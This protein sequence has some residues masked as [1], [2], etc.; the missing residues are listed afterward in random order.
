[1]E[2]QRIEGTRSL[3]GG[4]PCRSCRFECATSPTARR[5]DG[6]DVDLSHFHHR[7]ERALRSS[8][9]GVGYRLSQ[10]DR[11]NL[12]GQSPSVLAPAARALFAAVPYDRV[13]VT[14]RFGLVRGCDLKRERFVVLE[15]G[16]AIES[17]AGNPHDRE[18]DGQHIPFLPGRKVSRRVE[19]CAGRGVV[20]GLRAK[21][22]GLFGIAIVPKT[23]RVFRWI[24]FVTSPRNEPCRLD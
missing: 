4:R 23:N 21:T 7:I 6:R 16:S 18:F 19:H 20:K 13:P 14:I 22:R 5:L 3:F 15:G 1:A 17:E 10:C 12:P 24:H 11:R 2:P 9:I 8:R